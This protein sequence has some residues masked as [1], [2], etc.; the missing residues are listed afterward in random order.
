M[1]TLLNAHYPTLIAHTHRMRTHLFPNRSTWPTV[2]P[3]SQRNWSSFLSFNLFPHLRE[4]NV[5]RRAGQKER[6]ALQ[7]RRYTWL[8]ITG[9]SF[10]TFALWQGIVPLPNLRFAIGGGDVREEEEEDD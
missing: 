7:R 6:T 1:H 2:L 5:R 3:P 8:A 9:V 10:A 4:P